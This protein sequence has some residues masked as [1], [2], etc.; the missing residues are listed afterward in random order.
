MTISSDAKRITYNRESRDY[1]AT[2]DGQYIGS[3][4][5]HQAAKVALDDYA[6]DLIEQGLVDDMQVL[7]RPAEVIEVVEVADPNDA[8]IP[9]PDEDIPGPGDPTGPHVERGSPIQR[10]RER[11]AAEQARIA[12][13]PHFALV[14][15]KRDEAGAYDDMLPSDGEL[16]T[17]LMLDG[18]PSIVTHATL[19]ERDEYMRANRAHIATCDK[20]YCGGYADI[21]AKTGPTEDSFYHA[22]AEHFYS[23]IYSGDGSIIIWRSASSALPA[24]DWGAYANGSIET[25]AC[26]NPAAQ[27]LHGVAATDIALCQQCWWAYENPEPPC[28]DPSDGAPQDPQTPQTGG[29]CTMNVLGTRWTICGADSDGPCYCDTFVRALPVAPAAN[30]ARTPDNFSDPSDSTV[31]GREDAAPWNGYTDPETGYDA[32]DYADGA[33]EVPTRAALLEELFEDVQRWRENGG[34]PCDWVYVVETAEKIESAA[35]PMLM[36]EGDWLDADGMRIAPPACPCLDTHTLCEACQ[37][38]GQPWPAPPSDPTSALVALCRAVIEEWLELKQETPYDSALLQLA[39]LI[40]PPA[41]PA[42]RTLDHICGEALAYDYCKAPGPFLAKFDTF[43]APRQAAVT[44]AVA[45]W[46]GCDTSEVD[47][48]WVESRLRLG[49][50]NAALAARQER[51]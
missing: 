13:L 2:F 32:D 49:Y 23:D 34:Q 45:T 42:P 41:P 16:T 26:G 12:A 6:L 20:R 18:W 29:R 38:Q 22:C 19:A 27:L 24:A 7:S 46:L 36:P 47:Q 11:G 39:R 1:D 37:E 15:R 30:I 35:A 43:G 31:N 33:C 28:A 4:T 10:W 44:H 50:E 21:V 40:Y 17:T 48:L 5:T 9:L 3:F 8:P 51:R 14:D 25:C